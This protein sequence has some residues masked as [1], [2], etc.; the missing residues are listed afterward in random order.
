ME[1]WTAVQQI[2]SSLQSV[3][4][5]GNFDGMHRGHARV[6]AACV[7]RAHRRGVSSAAVTFD[8]HPRVVHHPESDLALIMPLGDRLDAIAVTGVDAVLVARYN[9]SLYSLSPEEFVAKYLVDALG[10]RE[11]VVGEDFRFGRGNEGDIETLRMLGKHYD[12]DVVMVSDI[13]GPD[14]KRWSSSWVRQCLAAGDVEEA[15]HILGRDPRLT[16]MV[17]HGHK[18]GRQLGFPTANVAVPE[19]VMIPADGVYA[20][21]LIRDFAGGQAFLPAAISIGMNPQ[22]S[23]DTRTVEAHVLGRTDLDLYEETVTLALVKRLRGMLKFSSVEELLEQMDADLLATA[24]AL[25][26]K[27][28]GRAPIGAVTAG[29]K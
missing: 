8:P 15:A 24:L 21:W 2:P 20:G 17:E 26:V 22:F 6:L 13:Q 28:A 19:G 10:A 25:G 1:I 7:D 5:I 12:F 16:G 9:R 3:V 23:G 11:V 27:K 14:G 29:E 4:T 18:R